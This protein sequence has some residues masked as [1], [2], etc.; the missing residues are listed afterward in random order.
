MKRSQLLLSAGDHV[1]PGLGGKMPDDVILGARGAY[2]LMS[3]DTPLNRWWYSLY[4][5][6]HN[7]YPVQA[8]YRMAQSLLGLKLAVEKAMAANG[9]KKP[10]HEQLAA[11]LKGLEWESPAGMIRMV[12]GN[13]HQAIQDSAIGRTRYNADTKRVDLVDIV[14]FSAE[15]VNPPPDMKSEEWIK[16]GFK[17]AK[18]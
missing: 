17:G 11:A 3:P 1:L 4:E 5:K 10:T 8:P 9:G 15:C 6:A 16:S 7:V 13:G 2:G 18:C 14:R 12:N